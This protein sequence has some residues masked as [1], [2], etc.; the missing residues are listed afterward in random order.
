V[1]LDS[2]TGAQ[3]VA[4]ATR[5][6]P[7]VLDLA[8]GFIVKARAFKPGMVYVPAYARDLNFGQPADGELSCA[9]GLFRPSTSRWVETLVVSGRSRRSP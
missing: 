6:A 8:L 9:V 3:F 2:A 5:V 7:A 1:G 4:C